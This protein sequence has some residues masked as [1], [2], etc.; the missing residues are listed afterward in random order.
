V[1]KLDASGSNFWK[2]DAAITLYAQ[3]HDASEVLTGEKTRPS[4]P[5]YT[6]I[7]DEPGALDVST[8]DPHNGEHRQLMAERKAFDD[9]RQSINEHIIKSAE[10]QERIK[11]WGRLDAALNMTFLTSIPREVYEAIQ[12]LHT[13]AEQY[14][15][16]TRRYR[17]GLHEAYTA[18][19]DFSKL[20]C[21]DCTNTLK[22]TDKFR[23][24]LNKLKDMKLQLPD[25]GVLY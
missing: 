20:R 25:K 2:W 11:H 19:A 8:L 22:F 18:W 7:I 16:I 4:N 21:A 24:S 15:E 23:A 14:K 17:E 1:P 3:I 13:A 12:G 9:D 6:G 5:S 10:K